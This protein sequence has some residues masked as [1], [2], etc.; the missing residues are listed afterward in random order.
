[1]EM[2]DSIAKVSAALV[3]AVGELENV[4]ADANNP[5][6]KSKYASLPALL[7]VVRPVLAKNG[8]ALIQ[9]PISYDTGRI[10]IETMVLHSSGEWISN[11]FLVS[12][13]KNDPQGAGAAVTY[14][15]RY[16]LVSILGIG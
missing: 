2:S 1:M 12:P 4:V 3:K 16:A 7:D 10:G 13:S 11:E 15:R 14:C 6:F 5:H 9:T 8:L